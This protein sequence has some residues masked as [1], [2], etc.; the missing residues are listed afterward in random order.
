MSISQEKLVEAMGEMTYSFEEVKDKIKEYSKGDLKDK[1]LDILRPLIMASAMA[2]AQITV[3][4]L[5]FTS[6]L[7]RK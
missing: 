2:G 3:D 7:K 1:E 5:G 4:K 6:E